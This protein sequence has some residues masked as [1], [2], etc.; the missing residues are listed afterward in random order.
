M[1]RIDSNERKSWTGALGA[2][3]GDT[4]YGVRRLANKPAFA[5]TIILTLG[6]SIGV[7]I[8]VF[9]LAN[10]LLIKGLPYGN[11]SRLVLLNWLPIGE[12]SQSRAA[13]DKWKSESDL[14]QD[15][16]FYGVGSTTLLGEGE[17]KRFHLANVTA[18]L[19]EVLGI[20]PRAGRLF[21]PEDAREGQPGVAIIS[22]HLW[23]SLYSANKSMLGRGIRLNGET[24]TLIGV[25]PAGSEFPA[26]TDVWTPN[27]YSPSA[28]DSSHAVF[29]SVLGVIK[30]GATIAQVD[31]Q[32]RAWLHGR[33]LDQTYDP[34]QYVS[35][36]VAQGLRV[37]LVA[38][39]DR[40]VILLFGG[41]MLVLLIGCANVMA[42]VLVDSGVR[43][44]EFSVRRAL[45][46]STGQ[47]VRQLI[48]EH[49]LIGVLGGLTGAVMAY[50]SL[51][52][53]RTYL[54][55][56]WPEFA[57]ISLD[58]QVLGFGLCISIFTGMIVALAP[59]LRL[60][61]GRRG[62]APQAGA[63]VTESRA[64][65]FAR[66]AIVCVETALATVL[67][68]AGSLFIR[69]LKNLVT[70]DCGFKT[71]GVIA[72]TVSRDVT[73][74]QSAAATLTFY[75]AMLDRL[76]SMPGVGACGGVDYLPARQ[77]FQIVVQASSA[78]AVVGAIPI[79]ADLEVAAPGYFRAM[80]IPLL[81]GRDFEDSDDSS[82]GPVTIIDRGLADKLWEGRNPIG[83][84]VSVDNG[85]PLE[86]IGVAGQIRTF[87]PIPEPMPGMYRPLAQSRPDQFSFVVHCSGPL[88]PIMSQI[89]SALRATDPDQP[90]EVATLESY[91]SRWS[92]RSRGI[93]GLLGIL[94]GLGLTLATIGVYGLVSNSIASRTREFGIRIALGEQ[95]RR[96]LIR[97]VSG[98]A[99]AIIP[100]L[101]LGAVL[102]RVTGRV[103]ASELYGVE[104]TSKA[105]LGGICLL[106]VVVAGIASLLAARWA[107]ILDP[108]VVLRQE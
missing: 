25:V 8:A 12:F 66:E 98:A 94:S 63:R 54:P 3:G 60:S 16:A 41:V 20:R 34:A 82:R 76:R 84:K 46:M 2:I 37:A 86:V 92:Q 89:G 40:S 58:G 101:V 70:A 104:P 75:R 69:T 97:S 24:Y 83:R 80:G 48:V 72:L 21:L 22:E 32:Q 39:L 103:F 43:E 71:D 29:T 23:Q 26:G 79:T 57:G 53:L 100:G 42:L 74:P 95:G 38:G 59:V 33:Q 14:I 55:T 35:N 9:S 5:F 106:M 47:M 88:K 52:Y 49:V 1:K 13:F 11:A 81:G 15:A 105:T 68:V 36:P 51:P 17:P 10:A 99:R 108:I 50:L 64:G 28:L 4:K 77:D 87:G 44:H 91:V 102:A 78:P 65:R 90:L 62:L 45:G 96:I 93:A 6:L 61:R 30:P 31:A 56:D 73:T 18:N 67:L 107:L 27:V 19:F 85:P 7:N